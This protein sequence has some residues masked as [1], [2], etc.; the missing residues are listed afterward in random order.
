MITY[1]VAF[2]LWIAAIAALAVAAVGFLESTGLLYLSSACSGI[3]ILASIGA[4]WTTRRR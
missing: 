1:A 3:A 4:V 2:A